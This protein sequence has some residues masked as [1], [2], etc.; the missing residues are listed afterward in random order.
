M[1]FIMHQIARTRVRELFLI[2]VLLLCSGIVLI[3]Y[4]AGLSLALG[5][6]LAGL[7]ISESE[8]NHQ[9]LGNIIPFK[10]IFS[11]FFFVSIGMMLDLTF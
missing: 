9:A 1:P 7:I 11:S 6:F 3:T 2:S 10:D 8:Y 4:Q 5:A